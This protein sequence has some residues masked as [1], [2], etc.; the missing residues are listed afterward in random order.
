M[1]SKIETPDHAFFVL[2]SFE[3]ET[4][5]TATVRSFSNAEEDLMNALRVVR[6]HMKRITKVF[7]GVACLIYRD[8][9]E[10]GVFGVPYH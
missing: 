1:T 2:E 10:D 6:P 7:C 8:M 4:T 5:E 3:G 9:D